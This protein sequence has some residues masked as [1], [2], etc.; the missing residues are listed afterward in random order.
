[1][2]ATKKTTGKFEQ[3]RV[4]ILDAAAALIN[5]NG[6][7]GMTF[8]D[9][10]RKVGLNTTSVTYYFK[11]KEQLAAATFSHSLDRIEGMV[12]EAAAHATPQERCN[13]YIRSTFQRI[14]DI[15]EGRERPLAVLS[16]IRALEDPLRHK[17]AD[18]YSS[19]FA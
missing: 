10:A 4:D 5:V 19:I 6:V 12:D 18:R 16:D 15:R 17:L 9:V 3:K 13:A 2:K 14:A 8:A 1:M 7:K 11:K